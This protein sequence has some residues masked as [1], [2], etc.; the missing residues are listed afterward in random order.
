[1]VIHQL[2]DHD[3]KFRNYVA[4]EIFSFVKEYKGLPVPPDNKTG[5]PETGK[6]MEM[7]QIMKKDPIALVTFVCNNAQLESG[8][9][10][11]FPR[12]IEHMR[13]DYQKWQKSDPEKIKKI[14]QNAQYVY[15][16]MQLDEALRQAIKNDLDN[17]I[18][19]ASETP[20]INKK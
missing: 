5:M 19:G 11:R 15:R 9:G 3:E 16:Q 14:I 10:G 2:R 6:A 12:Q 1:M 17:L 4:R 20:G 13:T 8:L 18:S 7:F